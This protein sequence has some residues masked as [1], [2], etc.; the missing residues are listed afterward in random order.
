M[1]LRLD[2][3]VN[4]GRC[5]N[6]EPLQTQRASKSSSVAELTGKGSRTGAKNGSMPRLPCCPPNSVFGQ[7]ASASRQ[8][9]LAPPAFR[10]S[11]APIWV[12]LGDFAGRLR[13]AFYDRLRP[14]APAL[15]VSGVEPFVHGGFSLSSH[16]AGQRDLIVQYNS[17][18]AP[19]LMMPD[20]P[21]CPLPQTFC[22]SLP[23]RCDRQN[24][25]IGPKQD[26]HAI[27]SGGCRR[28][29]KLFLA[30]GDLVSLLDGDETA[31]QVRDE[32]RARKS[33]GTLGSL[34]FG[35]FEHVWRK[36][37]CT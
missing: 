20:E 23:S 18:H 30:Q 11:I 19:T 16:P 6:R 34:P 26:L 21:L 9:K 25:I 7:C 27:V 2:I 31:S 15:A 29:L 12:S 10:P 24:D 8:L 13:R 17:S 4:G 3:A 14:G 22:A 35:Q 36:A 1:A 28:R 32:M 37:T 33:W 5:Q